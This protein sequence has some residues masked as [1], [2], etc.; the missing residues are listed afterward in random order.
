MRGVLFCDWFI[1]IMRMSIKSIRKRECIKK[2]NKAADIRK[3][4]TRWY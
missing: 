4:N 1:K 3:Y 2:Q